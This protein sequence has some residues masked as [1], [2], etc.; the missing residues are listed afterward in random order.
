MNIKE[1]EIRNMIR[2]SVTEITSSI[3][4]AANYRDFFKRSLEKIGDH[5]GKEVESP[6]DL[7][8]PEKA[9]FFNYI[10]T[11]WDEESGKIRKDINL[12]LKDM[13]GEEYIRFR[14]REVIKEYT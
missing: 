14:I 10:D 6:N 5:I 13:L 11:K 2:D 8:E 1:S 4:E 12:T 9:A 7:S 3:D